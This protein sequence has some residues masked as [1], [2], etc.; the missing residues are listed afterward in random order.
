[1]LGGRSLSLQEMHV[2]PL[3]IFVN[4]KQN[5]NRQ[6]TQDSRKHLHRKPSTNSSR[7]PS[8]ANRPVRQRVMS[9][10]SSASDAEQVT[11]LRRR[12]VALD[13]LRMSQHDVTSVFT[14][15][16]SEGPATPR[17]G[18]L[19]RSD[20]VTSVPSTNIQDKSVSARTAR[21][22]GSLGSETKAA[23]AVGASPAIATGQLEIA[24]HMRLVGL[25]SR[26]SEPG[27]PRLEAKE[28]PAINITG[29]PYNTTYEGRDPGIL[30]LL[31]TAWQET[32]AAIDEAFH[33]IPSPGPAKRRT[34][35]SKSS[36]LMRDSNREVTL[37]AHLPEHDDEIAG[38][39]VSPE[40]SYFAIVDILGNITIWETNRLERSVTTKPRLCLA[41]NSI[42]RVTSVCAIDSTHCFAVA[43][44]DG[45][46][47]IVRIQVATTG[48][49]VRP[50]KLVLHRRFDLKPDEGHVVSLAYMKSG[51][52]S[53]RYDTHHLIYVQV[54]DRACYSP[55]PRLAFE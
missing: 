35:R 1:M 27:S 8:F 54:I 11:E 17:P 55:R 47:D 22:K 19:R 12:L 10:D 21:S 7:R 52:S 43:G 29:K 42:G 26:T 3:T 37:I 36:R 38:L 20:S 39:V 40:L 30:S 44:T 15:V 48:T 13:S 9:Q 18:D 5:P 31:E 51:K 45:C 53:D 28:P 16:D 23:P 14:P 49:S 46:V 33:F 24:A 25:N 2:T 4:E 32:G 41:L 50:V 6:D 34:P